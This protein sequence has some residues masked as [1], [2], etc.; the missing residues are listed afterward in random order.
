MSCSRTQ[1]NDAGEAQ[2]CGPSAS[3]QAL[4]HCTSLGRGVGGGMGG[5]GAGLFQIGGTV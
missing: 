5:G 4:Y 2:T 1:W 3:S